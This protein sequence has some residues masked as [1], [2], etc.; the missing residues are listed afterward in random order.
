MSH[1]SHKFIK[2][3][4]NPTFKYTK[5][6]VGVWDTINGYV[7][8]SGLVW[9]CNSLPKEIN[10]TK[11]KDIIRKARASRHTPKRMPDDLPF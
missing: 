7:M 5:Y 9:T 1:K 3:P 4:N 6:Y 10:K 2:H 8:F 11:I